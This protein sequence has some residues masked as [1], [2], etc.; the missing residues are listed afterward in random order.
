MRHTFFM[1]DTLRDQLF[2]A[3]FKAL[4][5]ASLHPRREEIASSPHRME[6]VC[7]L[8][9]TA[10]IEMLRAQLDAAQEFSRLIVP[11]LG[12]DFVPSW[13]LDALHLPGRRKRKTYDVALRMVLDR[14]HVER[15]LAWRP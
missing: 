7:P 9:P 5:S 12:L 10:H 6:L 14:E 2:L 15:L 3:A 13:L 8:S 1:T 4:D 11:A